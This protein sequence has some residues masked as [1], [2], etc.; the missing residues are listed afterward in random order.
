MKLMITSNDVA[1]MEAKAYYRAMG[2]IRIGSDSRNNLLISLPSST[3]RQ[4][5]PKFLPTNSNSTAPAAPYFYEGNSCNR[6]HRT[7]ISNAYPMSPPT[8]PAP[9][10]FKVLEVD[11]LCVPHY[12]VERYDDRC[13]IYEIHFKCNCVQVNHVWRCKKWTA[14]ARGS[15]EEHECGDDLEDFETLNLDMEE[16]SRGIQKHG[17]AGKDKGKLCGCTDK[18]NPGV[19]LEERGCKKLTRELK[20]Y[21]WA[22]T[23][24]VRRAKA[25]GVVK[26]YFNMPET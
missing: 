1:H 7:S 23:E 5:E 6:H 24:T 2:Y 16:T 12:M 3:I 22:Q 25:A 9:I 8:A 15:N 17:C 4:R 11:N 14:W 19:P 18:L 13:M 21:Q 26:T 20:E 10:P